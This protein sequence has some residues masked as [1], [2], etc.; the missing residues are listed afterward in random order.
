MKRTFLVR[1]I[2]F[3]K[4]NGFFSSEKSFPL[5]RMSALR[6]K[7]IALIE[8]V[9]FSCEHSPSLKDMDVLPAKAFWR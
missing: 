6:G 1:K 2:L 8:M 9:F 3:V 4:R 7:S 5:N